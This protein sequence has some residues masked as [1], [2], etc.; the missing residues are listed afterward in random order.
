MP[1]CYNG[2]NPVRDEERIA[3]WKWAKENAIDQGAS[4]DKTTEMINNYFFGG[5]GRPEWISDILSGRKTPY[6]Y[7]ADKLW[8]AQANRRRIIQQAQELSSRQRTPPL[9]RPINFLTDLPRKTAT[10][11]HAVVFP[12]SHAGD[13]ALRPSTWATFF[14]GIKNTY[15][16]AFDP[17]THARV[18]AAMENHPLFRMASESGLDVG[19]KS[20]ESGLISGWLKGQSQRAWDMLKVMRFELWQRQMN[21]HM[22]PGMSHQQAVEMGKSIAGWANHA[23][24]SVKTSFG[25]ASSL[26]F[27]PKLTASKI[28]RLT[29]DPAQTVKTLL[30]WKNATPGERTAA[31]LR[32]SGVAQYVGSL[33]AFLGAN[34]GLLMATGSKQNV[35]FSDPS[36]SDFWKFKADGL[37]FGLPGMHSELRTIGQILGAAHM[38]SKELRGESRQSKINDIVGQYIMN[39]VNPAIGLGKDVLT[40]EDWQGR[41]MPWNSDPGKITK[42]GFDKR[43][44]DWTEFGKN[45]LPI[46]LQGPAGYFYKKL[47]DG[48]AS[49]LDASTIIKG[50]I[51]SGMGATGLHVSEEPPAKQEPL[52]QAVRRTRA[53]AQLR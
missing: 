42:S 19:A 27:G 15:G 16:G 13:L 29:V 36:K 47:K 45:Y 31:K 4:L 17:A 46:P 48:G 37:D 30:D 50:L 22:E 34:Q 23:T 6:R 32:L 52:H 18:M 5:V 49:A 2:P 51:L 44:L 24:G 35:N 38:G 53:A 20:H 28:A 26:L 3:I 8:M 40:A 12:I 1:A 41:P 33:A 39:K 21:K 11:G 43:R 10:F 9:L 25:K 7:V 14:R